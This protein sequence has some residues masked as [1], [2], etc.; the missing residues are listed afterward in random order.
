MQ[1]QYFLF[2]YTL[3]SIATISFATEYRYPVAC[4][5]NGATI[6]YIHQHAP[7]N[8]ELFA[9][10]I[11]TNTIEPILWSLFNP[12]GLQLLP[13]DSGF[14]FIDN[15]RLRIKSF[16]KRSP[17][18]VDFDEPIFNIN[19]L[20]WIDNDSCY[21]S[22]QQGDNFE[23]LLLHNDGTMEYLFKKNKKD[24][25]YPQKVMN[26][27]FYIERSMI[28]NIFNYC[29]MQCNYMVNNCSSQLV[30][31]FYD[32]P[33]I[34]LHMLSQ[35][36]G[37]VL[38][39]EQ[40]IESSATTTQF[41]YH[42]IIKQSDHW[43]KELLF[44]FYIPINLLLPGEQRIYESLLPLLPQVVENKVYFV[45]CVQNQNNNLE[46]YYYDLISKTIKTIIVPKKDGHY[47]V[48]MICGDTFY[49][50]GT[51]CPGQQEPFISFLT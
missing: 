4:L 34:F 50:G 6:F 11:H 14:S 5:N 48:P 36:E 37:F 3:I 38:E 7:M 24:C 12:A 23:L 26:T 47:F 15:G 32:K 13:N 17:K 35:E 45:N 25:M 8:I 29:I 33:I 19:G 10:N 18:T 49:C 44:S 27:L 42:H 51:I 22:G 30:I 21:C 40:N 39:Y 20:H 1:L 41:L 28:D 2:S 16:Q 31:N 46:P 43:E 9:W